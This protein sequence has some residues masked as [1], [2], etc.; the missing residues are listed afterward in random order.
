[1]KPN[2]S[3]KSFV[4]CHV[5]RNQRTIMQK[6]IKQTM[7]T[8]LVIGN[9]TWTSNLVLSFCSMSVVNLVINLF[10]RELD[11]FTDSGSSVKFLELKQNLKASKRKIIGNL[12]DQKWCTRKNMIIPNIGLH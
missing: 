1:M 9:S 2:P 11:S 7:W 6:Y 10:I 3:I 5:A 8:G 12:C 4:T